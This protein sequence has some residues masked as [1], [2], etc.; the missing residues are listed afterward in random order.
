MVVSM[1]SW[2]SCGAWSSLRLRLPAKVWHPRRSD[3]GTPKC[4]SRKSSYGL[5]VER[6]QKEKSSEQVYEWIVE[7]IAGVCRILKRKTGRRMRNWKVA[8]ES[9]TKKRQ[10]VRFNYI[11]ITRPKEEAAT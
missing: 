7:R 2:R 1:R 8:L 4:R 11:C 10:G 3:G 5:H 9:L 6:E